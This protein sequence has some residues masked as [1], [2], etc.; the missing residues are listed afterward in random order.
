MVRRSM[1]FIN[2]TLSY[3][4]KFLVS[5]FRFAGRPS[6]GSRNVLECSCAGRCRGLLR[7]AEKSNDPQW[8]WL[9]SIT[10]HFENDFNIQMVNA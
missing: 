9:F 7:V 5:R 4:F 8:R 2:H 6:S 3:Y 1:V 10:V